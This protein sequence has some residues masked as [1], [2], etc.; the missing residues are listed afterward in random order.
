M[1]EYTVT[2]LVVDTDYSFFVTALNADE[3]PQSDSLTLRAAAFP[4]APSDLA[5]TADSR[6]G[7]AIGLEWTAPTDGGSAI[8]SYTLAIVRENEEDQ[9]VYYG[10]ATST[11]LEGLTAGVEY[12]FKILATTAVGDSTWS[13]N[14]YKFLIVDLPSPPLDLQLIAFDDTLVSVKW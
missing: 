13:T 9:V 2:G 3:G 4:E 6:T 8:L 10:S 12:E 1:T 14:K 7:T 11:V 5:E